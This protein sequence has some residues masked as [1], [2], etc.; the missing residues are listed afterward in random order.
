[1]EKKY[2]TK[3]DVILH[4]NEIDCWIIINNKVYNITDYLDKHRGGKKI[5]LYYA[6]KDATIEFDEIRHTNNAKKI[7]EKYYIGEI[8]NNSKCVSC[9]SSINCI[10]CINK[11]SIL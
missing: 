6:G 11:C 10:S 2:Y 3:E 7:L 4:N 9:C 1:M 5:L 8:E